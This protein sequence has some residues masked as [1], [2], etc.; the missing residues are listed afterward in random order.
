MSNRAAP[1]DRVERALVMAT[2]L[3]RDQIRKGTERA[4]VPYLAH[5]LEVAAIVL[6]E[7]VPEDVAIAALLH[8]APE[9]AGGLPV[10]SRIRRRF[11][12][13]VADIVDACTDTYQTP[14]PPWIER[15]QAHLARLRQTR[16]FDI[17]LVKCADCLSNVRATL[18]DHQLV[19]D[20]VWNR[21]T[22]MPCASCQ[23]AWYAHVREALRP[24]DGSAM[25]FAALD[26]AVSTLLSRTRPSDRADHIHLAMPDTS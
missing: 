15:K 3:H 9:D 2:R 24:L 19:G 10:L 22:G 17:L 25:C 11:G 6:S 18:R 26:E 13:H 8:D 21:F 5:L 16:D 23:R 4:P 20:E 7:S 12:H 14:K 1:T